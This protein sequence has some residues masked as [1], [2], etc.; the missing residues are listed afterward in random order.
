M[1]LQ[2]EVGVSKGRVRASLAALCPIALRY[3]VTM[4][5]KQGRERLFWLNATRSETHL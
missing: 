3:Y 1:S 5:S 2:V 4:A